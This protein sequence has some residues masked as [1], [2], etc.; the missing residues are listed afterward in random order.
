MDINDEEKKRIIII[1]RDEN[2]TLTLVSFSP[3]QPSE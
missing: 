2:R 1:Q 3:S